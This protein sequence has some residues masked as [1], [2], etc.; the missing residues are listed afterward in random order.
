M[1]LRSRKNSIVHSFNRNF[2]KRADGN[3]IHHAFVGSP[4]MVT[5]IAISGRL[6]FDPVNDFLIN[7]DGNKVKLT[8]P[9]GKE[10]PPSGFDVEDAGYIEPIKD[11]INIVLNAACKHSDVKTFKS[12]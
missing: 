2:S 9:Y 5:A 11:G 10:L 1:S 4:E 12:F 7:K 8:P 3:P 6:D